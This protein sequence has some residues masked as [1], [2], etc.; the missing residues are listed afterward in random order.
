M[1]SLENESGSENSSALSFLISGGCTVD[2]RVPI[3]EHAAQLAMLKKGRRCNVH[4]GVAQ[5]ADM[6]EIAKIAD[7][8]SF[9]MIGDDETIRQVLGTRHTVSDY[10]DS[11]KKLRDKCRVVPHICIGLHGGEIRGEYRA[12]ELLKKLGTDELSFIV[13]RPTQGTRYSA[14]HPPDIK[15]TAKILASARHEFPNIPIHLGCMRP[16]G[17]YRNVLDEWAVRSGINTIVNPAPSAVQLAESL[18]LSIIIKK[19]CCV[20]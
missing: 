12:M 11:Y 7:T 4:V 6:T 19:E 16:G 15:E 17:S 1:K 9:D 2:G 3:R 8:V 18:D 5:E 10:A 20:L 13:F 14:C